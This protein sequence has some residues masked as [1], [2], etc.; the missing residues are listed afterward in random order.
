MMKDFN[1]KKNINPYKKNSETFLKHYSETHLHIKKLTDGISGHFL[2]K[3][4]NKGNTANKQSGNKN[5]T[6]LEIR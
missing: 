3:L 6:V 5:E 2:H 4:E 1:F